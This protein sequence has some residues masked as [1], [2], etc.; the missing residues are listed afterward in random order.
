MSSTMTKVA[1]APGIIPPISFSMPRSV[2]G[3]RA[4]KRKTS[5]IPEPVWEIGRAHV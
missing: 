3:L 5:Q 4:A 2:A 1:F